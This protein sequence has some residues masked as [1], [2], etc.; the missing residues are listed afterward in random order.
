MTRPTN[1]PSTSAITTISGMLKNSVYPFCRSIP[2]RM[3]PPAT[4]PH[5]PTIEPT[6]RSMPPVTMTK[7]MPIARNAFWATCFDISTRLAAVRK[8]G[9]AN[10]K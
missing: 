2:C 4:I 1:T 6:D 5:S 8:L 10:E 9:A 3:S 7:V